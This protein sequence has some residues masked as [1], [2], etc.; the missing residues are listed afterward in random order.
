MAT[1]MAWVRLIFLAVA[2]LAVVAVVLLIRKRAKR[3][4]LIVRDRVAKFQKN[5][6][7]YLD[8]P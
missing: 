2:A 6:T 3:D 8:M 7:N 1:A 4:D 5:K